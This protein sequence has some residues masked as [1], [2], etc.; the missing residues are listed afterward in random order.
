MYDV[1]V[2]GGGPVGSHV[3]KGLA[4][5]GH[6]VA[7]LEKGSGENK[8]ICCTGIISKKCYHSYL[9]DKNLIIKSGKSA[10]VYSPSGRLLNISHDEEQAY[11]I[12]RT[13]LDPVMAADAERAGAEYRH[14]HNVKNLEI[15]KDRIRIDYEIDGRRQTTDARM[16]V[17]A[18]GFNTGL[19]KRTRSGKPHDYVIGTQIEVDH[20]GV[21]QIEM[22]T[23]RHIAP[24]YFGWLVP[25]DDKK[26]LAGLMSK[27]SPNK[28]LKAFLSLLKEQGKIDVN[29]N[30]PAYRGITLQPR[31][32]TYGERFIV[33]GDAA[34]HVKPLTGGGIYFGLLCADIAV[35]NIDRALKEGNLRASG[36]A[37]YEK[38]WKRKLG[39]ELRICRLAQGFYARLNN[40]QLDR[41]FD[42]NNNSG[43]VDEI[44]ASDE[45]DF[46]FHS[47]VIRKAVNMRT[48]SKLLSC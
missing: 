46:D 37:P 45:L 22:Y 43:I 24:G 44:I 25:L 19:F 36:L 18:C 23:G 20:R 3:A 7:V 30:A 47:R 42:I 34:G 11:I 38:E 32:K 12:N 39:K 35:D 4:G 33:V 26:A 10:R 27:H 14:N 48:V 16:A 29:G 1:L 9:Q 17:I 28:Y 6:A 40:S 41:L 5:R 31:G 21:E 8:K 13:E 2:I 15:L